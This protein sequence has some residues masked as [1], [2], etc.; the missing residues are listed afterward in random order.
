LSVLERAVS[1]GSVQANTVRPL[2]SLAA[3]IAVRSSVMCVAFTAVEPATSGLSVKPPTV[4]A[5]KV[6]VMPPV[7]FIESVQV[8]MPAQPLLQPVKVEP[9][10]GVAVKVTSAP[11]AND[12]EQVAPQLI[13]AGVLVT[14]PLPLPAFV[15]VSAKDSGCDAKVAVMEPAALIE[16]VQVGMLAQPLLQP[17]KADPAAGVAVKVTSVPLLN[18]AEHVAPQLIPAGALVTVPV[19]LPAFVTVSATGCSANVAVTVLAAFSVT[20]HA[21][22]PVHAPLQ[23]V[24]IAP[25][26]GV[27]VSVTTVPL[28]NNAEQ[29][30]PQLTPAGA[31]VTVP[32][33]APARLTV[34]AKDCTPKFA[35]TDAAAVIVTVHGPVPEHP[36]PVQPVNV[37]PAAGVAVSVMAVPLVSDIEHVA[38]QLMPAGALVTVPDPAP[39]RLTV[40]AKDCRAKVAVTELAAFIVTVH[41]PVPVH[42]PLQPVKVAPA[43]GVAVSVTAVPLPKD[44]EH[45]VPQ[46]MPAGALVTVPDPAPARLTVSAKPCTPKLAVTAAAALMVTVH[47]PVPVHAPLQPVKVAPA[48]GVAVSVTAVPLLKAAEH[49]V[50]QLMPAGALVTVPD[51]APARFTVSAKDCTPKFAVID[52]AAL[53]VTVQVP[54]PEHPPP[55]QPVNV[56]PAAGVAVSVTAVPLPK[57][58]EHVVPQL[59]PAGVLVTVPDPTPAGLTVSAKDC[60]AKVAVTELAAFIVTV[61]VPVPVH[62]PLQPVKVAPAA[63]VAVSVTAVPA[64]NA[65]EQVVPQ[66]MPAGALVTMPDP[67]PARLTVSAKDC[68]VNVAVTELAAFIVTV[69]APV[70]VHAPLQPVKVTP[71]AGVAVSVTAVPLP[72]DAEQVV[73]Q[74]MPAGALV[75]VPAPAPARFTVSAKDC[76][77]KFAVIVAAA[78]IVTVQL[79]VP[80]HPPPDQ[81]V[82]VAPAA[83]VAVS[84]TTVPLLKVAEHVVPQLMPAGALVTVPDPAGMTVSAKDCRAKVAVTELAAFI[85]TLHV[86]VPVQAP[87]QPVK[88]APAAGAAV[89]VTAVPLL[90]A[91]E[92]VVPQLMPA[93]VLV[94]VPAPAPARL[95]LSA[96]DCRAKVAVTELAAFIVTVHVPVPVHA[97]LQPVNVAPAAGVAVSVTAVPLLKAAEQ[98][99]PQ[100]MPAG[101]L[102]T[103]PDPAPARLTVR[104]KDWRPKLAVTDVAAFIVTVQVP[105]PEQPPPVQPVNVAPAEGVAVSVTAVPLLNDAEQVA[106]QLMPAGALVTVPG[107]APERLTVSVKP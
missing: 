77:P 30:A 28:L 54:V 74:L 92:Q 102:V 20:V 10:A 41:V 88:V 26:P 36:P 72:K 62:A 8:G 75:T 40:R 69:H 78:L 11:L 93:G 70:P 24:K 47:V 73:P 76:T 63:G 99:D 104:A 42:A 48:A 71:A 56:A 2:R 107:P 66:L 55:D 23:P 49:V 44:A 5:P 60:R 65:A 21:P 87:L 32:D 17:V 13:P 98:V 94:T 52:A 90:K 64:A 3:S 12:A 50:P 95:T 29:V 22:V 106:P 58:A 83:G 33:P 61:H 89:S 7:A 43:A 82:N 79:P 39:A 19:P 16:S 27:A 97:P 14:V 101:A 91:A 96:K 85:V 103:V 34:S 51:P 35:V 80:E 100:L 25:A 86:P 57:A 105:V 37:A 6:A 53:I 15:T 67:A 1:V 59:M 84:V 18:E 31:L 46:L 9:A 45:V 81:P 68:R 38:P 4:V